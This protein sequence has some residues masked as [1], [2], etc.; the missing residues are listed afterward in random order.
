MGFGEAIKSCWGKYAE[1]HGRAPRSEYWYWF[2]FMLLTIVAG[3]IAWGISSLVL[4]RTIATVIFLIVAVFWALAMLLPS[5]AV[6]IRRLH[7]TNSSGWW[8]LVTF[9]PYVGG[10]VMIVWYCIK[11]TPGENRFG[12]D[13]LQEDAAE[14]FS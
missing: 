1:F 3:I 14:A 10:W 4:G 11:G 12:Y 5:L 9:V 2:L 13:P 6:A 7:D 8:Y